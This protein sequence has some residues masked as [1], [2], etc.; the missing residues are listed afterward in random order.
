MTVAFAATDPGYLG[1][2]WSVTLAVIAGDPPTV[3]E[4]VLLP[5]PRGARRPGLGAVGG[6]DPSRRSRPRRPAPARRGRSTDR[7]R[8]PRVRRSCR[9]GGGA[10]AGRRARAGAEPCRSGRCCRALARRRFRT[11]IGDRQAGTGTVR[12]LRVLPAARRVAR[13]TG[14]RLRQR[15]SPGRR[16]GCRRRLRLRCALRDRRRSAVEGGDEPARHRRAAAWRCT[17]GRSR[18]RRA[19]SRAWHRSDETEEPEEP[20]ADSGAADPGEAAAGTGRPT[21]TW[22]SGPSRSRTGLTPTSPTPVAADRP[23]LPRRGRPRCAA[24]HGHRCLAG[25]AVPVPRGRQRRGG[26]APSAGTPTG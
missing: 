5:G 2:Q 26:A 25:G 12:D 24:R 20:L 4:V 10:R 18:R 21:S 14:R 19:R 13:R 15:D 9:R 6:A 16:P 7:P 1:W 8:L 17:A 22:R 3:S 23:G 11:R